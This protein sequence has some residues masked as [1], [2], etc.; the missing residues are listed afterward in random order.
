MTYSKSGGSSL[1]KGVPNVRIWSVELESILSPKFEW[2]RGKV[3]LGVGAWSARWYF[4]GEESP[5][6]ELER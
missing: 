3:T 1:N 4:S 2:D 6:L 5:H